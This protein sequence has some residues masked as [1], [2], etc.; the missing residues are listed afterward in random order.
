M[1]RP[2]ARSLIAR[3]QTRAKVIVFSEQPGPEIFKAKQFKSR[4]IKQQAILLHDC[5]SHFYIVHDL[6]VCDT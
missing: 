2:L 4:A 3:G 6:I 1:C 5:L